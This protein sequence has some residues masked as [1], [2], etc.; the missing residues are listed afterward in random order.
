MIEVNAAALFSR[1]F[2]ESAKLVAT[3][4]DKIRDM[5]DDE[6]VFICIL[7]DEVESITASRKETLG[8]DPTDSMRV[9]NVLLTQ[10]DILKTRPNIL[11]L[12]TS[13]LLEASDRK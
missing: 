12:T 13:N 4:F 10:L 6:E 1:F 2:S 3:L 7:I 5:T 11:L 9:V 8:A